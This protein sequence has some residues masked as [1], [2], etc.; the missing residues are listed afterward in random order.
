M[1]FSLNER[2]LK[3]GE[4]KGTK[5]YVARPVCQRQRF[6]FTEL[7]KKM[8]DGST[9]SE[10]DVAAVFYK[11]VAS[12]KELCSLGYVVDAGP[13]GS[14]RPSFRSKSVDDPQKFDVEKNISHAKILFMAKSSFRRLE[15]MQYFPVPKGYNKLK[16]EPKKPVTPVIDPGSGL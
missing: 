5:I 14:F 3:V 11:F 7:C 10:P 12:L 1:N 2:V 6:T 16:K 13:L 4:K 15:K 8:S 9:V